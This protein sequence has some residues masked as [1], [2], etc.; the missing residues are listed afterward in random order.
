MVTTMFGLSPIGP[1]LVP[2]LHGIETNEPGSRE[3]KRPPSTRERRAM[4][5]LE[6]VGCLARVPRERTGLARGAARRGFDAC[7]PSAG[8]R[9]S[10]VEEPP[11]RACWSLTRA[12]ADSLHPNP[13]PRRLASSPAGRTPGEVPEVTGGRVFE[14][15]F[16]KNND[17]RNLGSLRGA[18][19]HVCQSAAAPPSHGRGSDPCTALGMGNFRLA[20]SRAGL[21]RAIGPLPRPARRRAA[22]KEAQRRP[23]STRGRWPAN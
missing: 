23:R 4:D 9:R 7:F 20:I 16:F 15:I 14:N 11:L 8:S 1:S 22:R 6:V 2:R 19:R 10:G 3:S 21:R 17:L 5:A 12:S 13:V 18:E